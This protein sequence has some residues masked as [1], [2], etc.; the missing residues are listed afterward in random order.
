MPSPTVTSSTPTPTTRDAVARGLRYVDHRQ[1]LVEAHPDQR[2]PR[3][4]GGER[5]Q[6]EHDEH[7]L[8][9][10]DR[11]GRGRVGP[12]EQVR[13]VRPDDRERRGGEDGDQRRDEAARP[14]EHD[15]ADHADDHH[16]DARPREG[17]VERRGQQRQHR[18]ARDTRDGVLARRA[19]EVGGE[20]DRDR[21]EQAEPVPV[22]DRVRQPLIE[23][24][25]RDREDVRQHAREQPAEAHE[26]RAARDSEQDEPRRRRR[27]AAA[28]R[29]ARTSA[30]RGARG[31]TLRRRARASRT[32]SS[33]RAPTRRRARSRR[34]RGPPTART[35][36]AA[37]RRASGAGRA[38][39][40]ATPH[41]TPV[42]GGK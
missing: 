13:V 14:R 23:D 24:V 5:A 6:Q 26:R 8:A 32:T 30:G 3:G 7:L 2:V 28:W 12:C 42:A 40:P 21:G 38:R 10:V 18:R 33:T 1:A 35:P 31:R 4:A 9:L 29:A 11:A 27:C 16:D 34:R 39:S 15:V 19:R 22:G 37:A 36:R 25:R 20:H 17:E 41:A